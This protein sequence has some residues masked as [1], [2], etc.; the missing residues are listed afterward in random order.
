MEIDG[1]AELQQAVRF[2]L[3]HIAAGGGARRTTPDSREGA[4]GSRL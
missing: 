3:F 4:D 1:D 2:G